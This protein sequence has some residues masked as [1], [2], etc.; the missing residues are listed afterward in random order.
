MRAGT[1]KRNW[2]LFW[3]LVFQFCPGTGRNAR[4]RMRWEKKRA[5]TVEVLVW[6]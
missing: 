6:F 2:L 3:C 1:S 5:A 4:K